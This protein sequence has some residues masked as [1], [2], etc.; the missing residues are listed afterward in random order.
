MT[1]LMLLLP[2]A[3]LACQGP[4]EDNQTNAAEVQNQL[5]A[6]VKDVEVLPPDETVVVETGNGVGTASAN[7]AT[8]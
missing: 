3:L 8:R 1:R 2:L 4:V 5:D 6:P 7:A